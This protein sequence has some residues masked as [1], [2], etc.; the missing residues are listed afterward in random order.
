MAEDRLDSMAPIVVV[1]A[2]QAGFSAVAKLRG[3]GH[4]G[5][6]TLVGN[7]GQ[8]PYQRPPLS[9]GYLM[10]EMALE[11][12]YFRPVSYYDDNDIT[13]IADNAATSI[14]RDGHK[15][16]LADGTALPYARL[17]LATGASPRP[18]PPSMAAPGLK[19]LHYVRTL[20]D[21]DAM[22]PELN[23]GARLLVI[24]GGYI[25]LEAASVA[26]KRGMAVTLVEAA[27]R[28]LQRVAA[29]E[30]SALVRTLHLAHGVDL[31]EGTGIAGLTVSNGRVDGAELADGSRIA[32]DVVI[33]G[34]GIL[35]NTALADAAG[36][37]IEN[38][39]SVDEYCRTSDPDILA[40]G[41][42]ASFPHEGRRVRLESVGN[43]IDMGE[44]AAATALGAGGPYRVLAWFWSD[45][46][47]ARLQ[48]AGLSG[49]HDHIYQRGT[50]IDPEHDP[51][52]V[53]Y[54]QG[55]RLLA[56]DVLNDSRTYMVA[57]RLIEAG[58]S[59]DPKVAIDPAT[60]MKSLLRA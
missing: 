57:K 35:P 24:G 17:I 11:R 42:C 33:A 36:L 6:V 48:I 30:T 47:D 37:T 41:D 22:A 34:I 58:K 27:P 1:G 14:D 56:V 19:G 60:E 16:V 3:L 15:V 2:G 23:A 54:Y 4:E 59:P 32:A 13:L 7:E 50:G 49:Q 12:L 51:L 29:P 9:K 45:Q 21:V 40:A 5:P 53:W 39:I 8:P 44:A 26:A 46:Y 28:I 10:G 43:A 38:G 20:A 18:L 25:G 55:D 31:R 52:S